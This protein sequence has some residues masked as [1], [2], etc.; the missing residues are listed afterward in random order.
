MDRGT[1]ESPCPAD[2]EDSKVFARK[3][4][5]GWTNRDVRLPPASLDTSPGEKYKKSKKTKNK[6]R[7]KQNSEKK[8]TENLTVFYSNSGDS[9]VTEVIR[10]ST[11][12]ILDIIPLISLF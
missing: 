9:S 2:E 1:Q 8:Y 10:T 3:A 4:E 11:R 7:M 6:L 5:M 12:F